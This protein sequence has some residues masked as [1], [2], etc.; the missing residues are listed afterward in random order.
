VCEVDAERTDE[1]LAKWE[2]GDI[3]APPSG[4]S[5]TVPGSDSVEHLAVLTQTCDIRRSVVERPFL[6]L[7]PIV[8]LDGANV[9]L[10]ARGRLP[11][12]AP[13]L[14][15]GETVFAD[16]DRIVTVHKQDMVEWHRTPGVAGTEERR[17]FANN[18]GRKFARAAL[19]N[20]LAS[21]LDKFRRR[22]I[23]KHGKSSREGAA[24]DLLED[25]RVT[26]TPSWD[27]SEIDVFV[28]LCPASEEELDAF[29][30]GELEQFA[31]SWLDLCVP[32][33]A[34]CSIEG[35]VIPL[36]QLSAREYV[37]SDPLDL[38]HLSVDGPPD[39]NQS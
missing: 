39:T 29:G 24:L 21:A 17:R 1:A 30:A 6:S 36:D 13:L 4:A 12:F 11:R 37:D 26:G 14:L 3:A 2:Q 16:L 31:E 32:H 20:D 28:L 9:A 15:D 35:S 27:A 5:V 10:A 23:K 19:P 18:C 38:G 33:G 34:I 25:I 8:Q 7:A 22:V